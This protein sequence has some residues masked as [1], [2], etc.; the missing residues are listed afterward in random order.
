MNF[1]SI[2][3][4]LKKKTSNDLS[5]TGQVLG[6]FILKVLYV[7]VTYIAL[8]NQYY[9]LEVT[10]GVG[11]VFWKEVCASILFLCVVY[12]VVKLPFQSDFLSNIVLFLSVISYI[13]INSAFALNDT[14]VL[15]FV[16]TNFYFLCL[17]CAIFCGE[18]LVNFFNKHYIHK[19]NMLCSA[20]KVKQKVLKRPIGEI[21]DKAG[22]CIQCFC[23]GVCIFLII[24]KFCYNGFQIPFTVQSDAVYAGRAA[25]RMY[26]L[27]ISGTPM[28]YFL[29]I[30]KNLSAVIIPFYILYSMIHKKIFGVICGL[31]AMCSLYAISYEKSN[32][33]SIVIVIGLYI[34]YRFNLLDSFKKIFICSMVICLLICLFDVLLSEDR[35]STIYR[36]LIRREMYLP[37]WLNTLYYDFFNNHQNLYWHQDAFFWEKIFSP[38]YD[39][40]VL[41]LINNAY[42]F[43]E[44]PSPN[45]GLF[46]EA[47]MHFGNL[48]V[49]IYPFLL[50]ILINWMNLVYRYFDSVIKILLAAL[51]SLSLMNIPIFMTEM[52]LSHILF[53]CMVGGII[54]VF[55]QK[56]DTATN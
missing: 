17:I 10:Y 29:A 37:A 35:D 42:F 41:E 23:A 16:L 44:V 27:D 48:G 22:F 32:L 7:V 39:K 36:L 49:V 56:M 21:E 15:F 45:T 14:S 25:Y 53:A 55:K 6:M 19:K 13:P 3:L 46:A 24:H 28:A 20:A 33:F 18:K 9:T 5:T 34:L 2:M 51:F 54:I 43:G 50:S 47:Y 11:F 12:V 40:S 4:S 38:I 8:H 52:V 26:T 30:I 31:F 1:D